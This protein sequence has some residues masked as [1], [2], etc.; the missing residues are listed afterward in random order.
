[1]PFVYPGQFIVIVVITVAIM[2]DEEVR[3]QKSKRR[4]NTKKESAADCAKNLRDWIFLRWK[5]HKTRMFDVNF[6][7]QQLQ[8][9]QLVKSSPQKQY[10]SKG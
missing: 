3:S 2:L 4:K 5:N 7:S 6:T 1:M 10:F 9:H 8:T